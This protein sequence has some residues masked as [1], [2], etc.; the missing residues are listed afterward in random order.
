[1]RITPVVRW[2]LILNVAAYIIDLI[3]QS[4][5]IEISLL[6]GLFYAGSPYFHIWQPLTYMFMHGGLWHLVFNMFALWMFGRI[7]EQAWGSQ[8]FLAFYLICGVGAALTQE[9]GQLMGLISLREWTAG[10][11]GAIFGVLLAFGMTF[12][13]ER[14]FI[15]PIPFPIKAK[16]FVAGYALL[17]LLMGVGGAN[18][19]TAHYAHLG[20]MLF[21][22][23]LILFWRR[24][25]RRGTRWSGWGGGKSGGWNS[26][27][28]RNFWNKGSHSNPFRKT[29]GGASGASADHYNR[30]ERSSASTGHQ[31]DYTYNQRR[32]EDNAEIDR[33]L[34]KIRQRGYEGLTADEKRR[35]FEAS[36]RT[37][38]RGSSNH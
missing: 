23:I 7:I 12:P 38:D 20:G 36:G 3:F 26:Q 37:S 6:F 28:F 27:S 19:N 33:I 29:R 5:G 4:M 11:S 16:Y 25:A 32:R 31:A 9:L 1:M 15:F 24:R 2:L 30:N 35:L 13:N 18:D 10:A 21:G 22:L 34:D 14:L 8:R 17:E